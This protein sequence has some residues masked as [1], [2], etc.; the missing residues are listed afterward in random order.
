[1][2]TFRD[3][4]YLTGVL[5]KV[6]HSTPKADY[7]WDFVHDQNEL[8]GGR[9]PKIYHDYC[10]EFLTRCRNEGKPFYFMVNS[11]DPHRPFHEPVENYRY[12]ANGAEPPSRLFTP[13]E[14]RVPGFVP[15]LPDVR[16]EVSYYFNSV[17]R[18]DDTFGRVMAA[19][20]E[21]GFADN[22]LVMFLSDNG[23]SLPFAKCN[24]YLASTHTPWMVRW[25]GVV[26]GGAVDKEHFISGIDFMPTALEAAGLPPIDSL[27]GVSFVPLLNGREQAGRDHVFTQIDCK[28]GGGA[29]PMRCIQNARFGYIFTAWADG[30]FLYRNNNEGMTMKAM[31]AAAPN[32][33][34]I[35]ERVRMF[36]YRTPEEFY[37]L[38]NDPNCLKNLID[39]PAYAKD[40]DALRTQLANQMKQSGDPLLP[41]FEERA[42]PKQM[43]ATMAK[44]YAQYGGKKG[45]KSKS[46]AKSDKAGGARS[47]KR[48]KRESGA[49]KTDG[50]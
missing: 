9:S 38:Q 10:V 25:P 49:R 21:T 14:I 8:G 29:V 24:T 18:L 22:T 37:D 28:A 45:K 11:H 5:G 41:S 6:Q 43:S 3:A 47:G 46:A 30:E 19:L 26:K 48:G 27:D 23:M 40:V 42:T 4:G 12:K 13:D 17:R 33:P 16:K 36:R 44:A 31:E 15:D 20:E 35:A 39:D 1:M 34:F 7:V 32:D 50:D 2:Q